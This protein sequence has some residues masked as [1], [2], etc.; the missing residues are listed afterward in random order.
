MKL[1]EVDLTK[2]LPS[3]MKGDEYDMALA[4]G[5]S[6]YFSRQSIESERVVIVGQTDHLNEAELDQLAYDMNIFWYSVKA[7]IEIKRKLIKDAPIVFNKL[8]TVWA[9]ERILNSYIDETE[10]EEWFDYGGDPHHFRIITNNIQIL[11]D[12]LDLF[13]EILTKIKR[14]SQWLENVILDLRAKGTTYPA[15]GYIEESEEHYYFS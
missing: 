9:I 14:R 7:D 12:E 10:L 5:M 11:T 3:F 13:L 6:N 1:N 2:M 15:I 4:E 8:G